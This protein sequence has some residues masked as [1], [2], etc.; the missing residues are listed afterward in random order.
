MSLT[1]LWEIYQN[2]YQHLS[3]DSAAAPI[4]YSFNALNDN[5]VALYGHH[6]LEGTAE[7][8]DSVYILL[9]DEWHHVSLIG[10][11]RAYVGRG[12][13][14]KFARDVR[15][16]ATSLGDLLFVHDRMYGDFVTLIPLKHEGDT[17]KHFDFFWMCFAH[18][19]DRTHSLPTQC[20]GT[21]RCG[22]GLH[23]ADIPCNYCCV[24]RVP[25]HTGDV[26]DSDACQEQF[27][28]YYKARFETQRIK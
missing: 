1:T 12:D 6:D 28:I 27:E 25:L 5:T 17:R 19:A 21:C 13:K 11:R 4:S 8:K 23:C 22:A 7:S 10:N 3:T 20:G 14:I 26:C 2:I 16:Y 9:G 24:C 15:H 18:S